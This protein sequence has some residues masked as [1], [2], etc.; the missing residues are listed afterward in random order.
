MSDYVTINI[1]FQ[2]ISGAFWSFEYEY[3]TD[4]NDAVDEDEEDADDDKDG[5]TAVCGSKVN[6]GNAEQ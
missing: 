1:M 4:D 2:S 6:E 5:D 3:F